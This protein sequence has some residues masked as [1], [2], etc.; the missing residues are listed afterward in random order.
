M[1]EIQTETE[2]PGAAASLVSRA[3]DE[4]SPDY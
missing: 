4:G 2:R 1:D 3:L